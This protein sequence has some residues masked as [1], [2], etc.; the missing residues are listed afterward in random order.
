MNP[1]ITIPKF[2]N[3]QFNFRLKRILTHDSNETIGQLKLVKS[4]N[5]SIPCGKLKFTLGN[6]FSE[7]SIYLNSSTGELQASRSLWEKQEYQQLILSVNVKSVDNNNLSDSALVII[8][9]EAEYVNKKHNNKTCFDKQDCI[10]QEGE[11]NDSK[12]GIVKRSFMNYQAI[13]LALT[14]EDIQP[15]EKICN[16]EAWS[17]TAKII[18]PPGN[19]NVYIE[20]YAPKHV[21]KYCGYVKYFG[22]P[23]TGRNVKVGKIDLNSAIQ[24][25]T[26]PDDPEQF[27]H[28]T[29]GLKNVEVKNETSSTLQ[30]FSIYLEFA[31][32]LSESVD[33]TLNASLNA[34]ILLHSKDL[35]W[36]GLFN[37]IYSKTCPILPIDLNIS[38]YPKHMIPTDITVVTADI[39]LPILKE[40]YTFSVYSV[41]QSATIASLDLE[42]GEGFKKREPKS[43]IKTTHEEILN[44]SIITKR[45]DIFV[46]ELHNI[47]GLIYHAPKQSK[48]VKLIAYIQILARPSTRVIIGFRVHPS[49]REV[50]HK[51][52]NIPIF[53]DSDRIEML[54]PHLEYNHS[55][56]A[57]TEKFGDINFTINFPHSSKQT[58][59]LK[60]KFDKFI[61]G[62]IC[63]AIITDI[64]AG[65]KRRFPGSEKRPIV[66]LAVRTPTTQVPTE[67]YYTTL[68]AVI[69][70]SE[71]IVYSP[72]RIVLQMFSHDSML[73][74]QKFCSI[75]K[76]LE[77]VVPINAEMS[78]N[79]SNVGRIE[80][81][82]VFVQSGN[83]YTHEERSMTIKYVIEINEIKNITVNLDVLFNGEKISKQITFVPDSC[84]LPAPLSVDQRPFALLQSLLISRADNYVHPDSFSIIMASI[85]LS[86]RA[87]QKYTMKIETSKIP[88]EV[89]LFTPKILDTGLAITSYK[90]QFNVTNNT[91]YVEIGNQQFEDN[92]GKD[93]AISKNEPTSINIIMPMSISS[94]VSNSIDLKLVFPGRNNTYELPFIFK[95]G[96]S[97]A[98][99]PTILSSITYKID[100]INFDKRPEFNDMPLT[101]GEI[102]RIYNRIY[103]NLP[104][105]EEYQISF[106]TLPNSLWPVDIIDI[107]ILDVSR[108]LWI[109]DLSDYQVIFSSRPG[110]TTT[111]TALMKLMICA[112]AGFGNDIRIDVFVRPWIRNNN[113]EKLKSQH[114]VQIN[115]NIKISSTNS[116]FPLNACT[117]NVSGEK[118]MEQYIL[119]TNQPSSV[120]QMLDISAYATDN[121][122]RQ[123]GETTEFT[124][125]IK[126]PENSK[127]PNCSVGFSSGHSEINNE[128]ELTILNVDIEFGGV[129][130]TSQTEKF[131]VEYTSK[132]LN[133]QKDT[134]SIDFGSL[135]NPGSFNGRFQNSIKINVTARVSDSRVVNNGSKIKL[136]MMV[137]FGNFTGTTE[138][139]Q[140]I[141]RKGSERAIISTDLQEKHEVGK[142]KQ[143]YSDGDKLMLNLKI[144]M[145]HS[146]SLECSRHTLNI[147]PGVSVKNAEVS[148]LLSDLS[149]NYSI[150]P[151][152]KQSGPLQF[153]GGFIRFDN[154]ISVTIDV[155]FKDKIILPPHK[156]TA[157][158]TIVTELVCIS[159]NRS[160]Q[161]N[162][163][164]S[165]FLS[166]KTVT[167]AD[168]NFIKTTTPHCD[169]IVKLTE[170]RNIDS[171]HAQSLSTLSVNNPIGGSQS[172]STIL[173]QPIT[174]LFDQ[175]VY[176]N[177]IILISLNLNN[178][179]EMLNISSTT[180][181]TSFKHILT[182]EN[183]MTKQETK[184]TYFNPLLTTRGLHFI[185]VQ[186]EDNT[187][188]ANFTVRIYGCKAVCD[189]VKFDPCSNKFIEQS[190]ENKLIKTI[191]MT[192]ELLIYCDASQLKI[193]NITDEKHCFMITGPVPTT[194]I[195]MGQKIT[196]IIMLL[197]PSN[198]IAGK[199]SHNN[200]TLISENMG[201]SWIVINQWKLKEMLLQSSEIIHSYDTPWHDIQNKS[202]GDPTI[203]LCNADSDLW[204]FCYKGISWGSRLITYW[205][206]QQ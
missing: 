172:N 113:N 117:F 166:K 31:V 45:I 46:E 157:K 206:V 127:L 118:I 36:V 104:K 130:R 89:Q 115:G 25:E 59:S 74:E 197:K 175:L 134:A 43:V 37:L 180:D 185:A 151:N 139:F 137:N 203:N 58:Y 35:V 72:V 15:T 193:G 190:T 10:P 69:T 56:I 111:D 132:Y 135:V 85:V 71:M 54:P 30:S 68:F 32:I 169:T 163:F 70:W 105:C 49:N 181:G 121:L 81:P 48:T 5:A 178:K 80:L 156:K 14:R 60:L 44:D 116:E 183:S 9:W 8:S 200:S 6:G 51:E 159:N 16:G 87:R 79:S 119:Q 162:S 110:S 205:N 73:V 29:V 26:N 20:L 97:Q 66:V 191:L 28:I 63:Y 114:S 13:E 192:K 11:R 64:G 88:N 107:R 167:L 138:I 78:I 165:R 120:K 152:T 22:N 154:E 86:P 52:C 160:E 170:K 4:T 100:A 76:A 40:N 62:E 108:Y 177:Q 84:T 144:K 133:G 57:E 93:G 7:L 199:N 124:F 92:R 53:V 99:P 77:T 34:G 182:V 176:I 201:K 161:I 126:V 174:I 128:S 204:K 75:G 179:I 158:Y 96:P 131:T 67:G 61:L 129:F 65:I 198:I 21:N 102:G 95:I 19:H 187:L 2:E 153:K 150:V 106:S 101:P 27:R 196:D 194:V 12:S 38:S 90:F 164:I 140:L 184:D 122:T 3:R 17:V 146:S 189:H 148:S 136:I 94:S 98:M 55:S 173:H 82:S 41:G 141:K 24:T 155:Y 91:A 143:Y 195:D 147:Y 103:L 23:F 186:S 123:P 109:S 168:I 149:F 18:F 125:L 1:M 50:I 202:N 145:E 171:C 42:K 83:N 47:F 112:P 39:F 142:D 33:L 188:K